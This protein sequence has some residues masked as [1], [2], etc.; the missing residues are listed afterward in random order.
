MDCSKVCGNE[1][2]GL[3]KVLQFIQKPIGAVLYEELEIFDVGVVVDTMSASYTICDSH[4]ITSF[5]PK[6]TDPKE[7]T[8][9]EVQEV[10]DCW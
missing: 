7:G 8:S 5:N 1:P 2:V 3:Q 10:Q 9:R 6:D 4:H